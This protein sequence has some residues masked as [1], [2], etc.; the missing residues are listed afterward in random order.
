MEAFRV[1]LGWKAQK[2]G[3]ETQA[4]A[5]V[6]ANKATMAELERKNKELTAENKRLQN[7][8]EQARGSRN[9]SSGRGGLSRGRGRGRGGSQSTYKPKIWK[10]IV[11]A[12]C[13]AFNMGTCSD[14]NCRKLHK[15]SEKVGFDQPCNENHSK[16]DH[17]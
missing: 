7:E 9:S 8:L 11:S 13:L 10:D 17:P 2:L 1:R 12:Y 3:D 16:K 5:Y 6:G 15:C 4:S 14:K